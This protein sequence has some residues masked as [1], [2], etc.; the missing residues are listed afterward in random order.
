MLEILFAQ[1]APINVRVPTTEMAWLGPIISVLATLIAGYLAL[2]VKKAETRHRDDLAAQEKQ[3]AIELEKLKLKFDTEEREN[4]VKTEFYDNLIRDYEA[5][6]NRCYELE[7]MVRNHESKIKELQ[8]ELAFFKNNALAIEARN[9]LEEVMLCFEDA[10]W[11]H[12]IGANKWYLNEHYCNRFG[13]KRDNFWTP[14]N[15]LA[16]YDEQDAL[17][18]LVH[19]QQVLAAGIPFE[20]EEKTR[21]KILDPNCEDY[22]TCRYR[23]VP[24]K[25]GKNNYVFGK[26]LEVVDGT[27]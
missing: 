12:D 14:I 24:F 4:K 26:L 25:I 27:H 23:K 16:H 15:I 3:K 18:Y 13:I 9:I 21:V 17:A 19:D 2:A 8:G 20:F 7:Q 10:A 6:R 5:V 11:I 22:I 1:G